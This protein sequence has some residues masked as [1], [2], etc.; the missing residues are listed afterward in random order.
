VA[1]QKKW[2]QVAV[3]LAV[4]GLTPMGRYPTLVTARTDMEGL[5]AKLR[6]VATGIDLIRLGPDGDGGYLVPDDLTGIQ[7]CFSPGVSDESGFE[8]DCADR[9]MSVYLADASVNAPAIAHPSFRFTKKYVGATSAGDFMTMDDW[10]SSSPVGGT[11]DL[12]LQIDIEGFEYETFLNMSIDLM[13]RFRIIVAEFHQ[14]DEYWSKTFFGLASRTF[15]K[16]LQTHTCVHLHPN[17]CC[18]SFSHQNLEIPRVMEFTFLRNDRIVSSTP[19]TTL[20]NLLD[21]GNTSN[22]ELALS[23]IWYGP[24][25]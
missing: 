24:D 18:G 15:D 25:Q 6:P 5:V 4:R 14:L 13:K 7:A 16:I 17:N 2:K 1:Y 20:P 19:V 11:S 9:G 3:G 21:R 23:P 8:R 10:V 22:A 12:L